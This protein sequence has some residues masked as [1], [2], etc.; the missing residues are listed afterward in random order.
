MSTA[1][2]LRAFEECG[3]HRVIRN[4]LGPD[5]VN[6]LLALAEANQDAF[7]PAGVGDGILDPEIRVSLLLRDLGPLRE[8]LK[9]RFR[10][11]MDH[12]VA[13]LRLAP[14]DLGRVE[15]E[16]AAHGDGAFF[17]RHIDTRTGP[18][19]NT[20]DRALTGVLYFHAQPKNY[21]GGQLR[22]HSIL[23]PEQGGCVQDITPE[24]DMLLLFPSWLPHEVRP[25]VCPSGAFMDSRFAINCWFWSR[26]KL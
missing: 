20:M 25:I 18:T 23:P 14:F 3:P 13:E 4:F 26:R 16:L 9:A 17:G 1:S 7:K 19:D 6:Q 10:A 22:L 8:V 5:L 21:G 2:A 24:R 15:I 12:A 11:I